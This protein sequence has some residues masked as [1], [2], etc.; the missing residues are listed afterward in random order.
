MADNTP[1]S[2]EN[3]E[4]DIPDPS[5]EAEMLEMKLRA[6][7]GMLHSY[8][9]ED[10]PPELHQMF[11]Q[12]VYDFEKNAA[13]GEAGT[14]AETLSTPVFDPWPE[15]EISWEKGEKLVE[16]V[17]QWYRSNHVE[18]SF[19]YDYP[20]SQRYAFLTSELPQLPNYYGKVPGML[21]GV[22]Y[23]EYYPNHAAVIEENATK[24]LQAFFD[25]NAEAFKE[26][27]WRDQIAPGKGPYDGLLL[28]DY[29]EKWFASLSGFEKKDFSI[30]EISYDWE[31]GEESG[32]QENPPIGLGYAEGMVG[33]I[34]HSLL[35]AEPI[36]M[37]GPFKFYFEWREDHW[38]I[39][40][41]SF[42]GLIVPPE[43]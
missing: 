15:A 8:Q 7:F 26:V 32:E 18:V 39:I 16:E 13:S 31:E 28:I 34:V 11:L 40:Y 22:I 30:L 33:Y 23:E 6:E 37:A 12:Q 4:G 36:R 24:F 42:P 27:I 10:L 43:V 14:F 9:P 29:L 17:S 1:Q 41:P 5:L 3:R 38:G 35:Q 21:T 20:A 19:A 25:R 2:N